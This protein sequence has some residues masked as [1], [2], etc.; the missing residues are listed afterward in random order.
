MSTAIA[1]RSSTAP[2]SDLD[3]LVRDNMGLV[4]HLV[5]EIAGRMPG[6]IHR[7]DLVSAGSAA[8][9]LAARTWDPARGVPFAP[10][11]RHRIRGAL[12]DE[13]R[14][15]DWATRSVRQL[16]RRIEG[17]RGHLAA[18]LGRAPADAEVA[19]VL[20]IGVNELANVDDDVQRA[21]V[22]SL[23]GFTAGT[24]EDLVVDTT[25]GP[26][27]LLLHRERLG[28]LRDAVDALPDRLRAV[29][30][31]TFLHERSI[32]EVAAEIGVS[33]SRISQLRTE[34]LRLLHVGLTAHL[35][36][37]PSRPGCPEGLAGR[38][39]AD[40]VTRLGDTGT[41][42]SRLAR[43]TVHGLPGG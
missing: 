3:A 21:V 42:R 23:H 7:D 39:C 26:E 20:G 30:T 10:Y 11:A 17:V 29:I 4:G 33:E 36:P 27:D 31:A 43:T 28:Y 35:Y 32:A 22:L 1:P 16:A 2:D 34:G 37:D 18:T 19:E 15:L 14:G 8:L 41:L 5:R 9:V 25:V 12:L 13:L 24:A 40:Y 6:H 38:R